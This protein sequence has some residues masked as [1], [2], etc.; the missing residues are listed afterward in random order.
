MQQ[1]RPMSSQKDT[2][3][4]SRATVSCRRPTVLRLLVLLV[5][6]RSQRKLPVPQ[7]LWL[8]DPLVSDPLPPSL[9]TLHARGHKQEETQN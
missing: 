5:Q 7:R 9:A 4:S 6:D 8:P 2:L 3:L 1:S